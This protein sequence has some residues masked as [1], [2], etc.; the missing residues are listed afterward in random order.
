MINRS[1]ITVRAKQPFFD[2]LRSLPDRAKPDLTLDE[3]NEEPKV[4]L[5]P[6]YDLQ[7][8]REELLEGC[9]DIVF[10]NQ[11]YEWWTDEDQWPAPRHLGL[12]LEWFEVEFHS[13]IFDLTDAPL[14]DDELEG[15]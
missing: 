7:D 11:L 5:L 4:Y 14:F 3:V 2:W 9:C 6:E 12:F 13:R 8:E 1:A 10:E 15:E